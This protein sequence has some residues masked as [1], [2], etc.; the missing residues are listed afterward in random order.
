MT[1][2]KLIYLVFTKMVY[3]KIQQLEEATLSR[4][5]ELAGISGKSL[6]NDL[7]CLARKNDKFRYT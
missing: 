2:E 3:R 1:V 5:D 6:E 4:K 7:R